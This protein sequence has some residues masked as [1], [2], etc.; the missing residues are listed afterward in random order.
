MSFATDSIHGACTAQATIDSPLGPLLLAR[1]AKGL[2]GVW[3]EGQEHHPGPLAAPE[4]PDDPVLR[5]TAEQFNAY[6]A[7]RERDFDMPLDLLGTPFQRSVWQA[8]LRIAAG[9]TRSYG[10]IAKQ[11]GSPRATRAVGA[12]VGRNPLSVIVPCHRVIGSGGALTGY[13]GGLARK[14]ALLALEGIA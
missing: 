10:D 5:Q 6:F 11:V 13:A 4:L 2:A 3:F 7:G 12:A 14:R 9:E 8:L 1:T